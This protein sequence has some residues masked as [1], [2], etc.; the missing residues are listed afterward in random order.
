MWWVR[1]Y[2]AAASPLSA[3]TVSVPGLTVCFRLRRWQTSILSEMGRELRF[4]LRCHGST[5]PARAPPASERR[6]S[7]SHDLVGFN[8]AAAHKHSA[9]F[10]FE[11]PAV[12]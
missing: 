2:S 4:I 12:S 9:A 11:T 6:G 1:A 10:Q 7:A 8:D 5:K 3:G